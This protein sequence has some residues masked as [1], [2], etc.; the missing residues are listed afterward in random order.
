MT[1][2]TAPVHLY[3]SA[4]VMAAIPGL[5]YRQL[6]YWTRTGVIAAVTDLPG[7]GIARGYTH[8]E[9]VVAALVAALVDDLGANPHKAG[10]IARMAQLGPHDGGVNLAPHIRGGR[11]IR[12]TLEDPT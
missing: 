2:N 3:T 9:V 10:V 6:D 1:A 8:D 11:T 5:T 7:S 4:E 12:I